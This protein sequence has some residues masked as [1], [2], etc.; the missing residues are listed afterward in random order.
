MSLAPEEDGELGRLSE[1]LYVTE[2]QGQVGVEVV[3]HKVPTKPA[4]NSSGLVI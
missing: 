2:D 1:A 4:M 3:S